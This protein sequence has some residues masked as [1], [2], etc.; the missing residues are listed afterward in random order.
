MAVGRHFAGSIAAAALLLF[1][2]LVPAL[3]QQT[4]Q[5]QV[6]DAPSAVRKPELPPQPPAPTPAQTS[7]PNAASP[8]PP[9]S[10]PSSTNP[11]DQPVVTPRNGV[12]QPSGRDELAFKISTNVNYVVLPVLVKDQNG[13]LVQGLD[14]K[15]FKVLENNTPQRIDTFSADPFPISAAVVIDTG[16]PGT[17][18][19]KVKATLPS[20]VAAFAAF[21]EVSIFT[22][23][24]TWRQ[25]H[26]FSTV[27][28]NQMDATLE[29]IRGE[30]G[31][32]GGVPFA[33]GPFNSPPMVNGQPA[34][35]GSAPPAGAQVARTPSH[36]LNDAILAAAQSLITRDRTRR[37]IIF[38]VSD[39]REKGSRTSFS[40]VVK[41]LLSHNI[42][43][44]AIGVGGAAEPGISQ[45]QKIHLP[46]F[47]AGNI[48]P[49]YA[50][51]TGGESF[52][53]LSQRNIE[54]AYARV[55]QEARNQYT[56]GYAAQNP[57][58]TGYRSIEVV[59]DR[60][61]CAK[62]KSSNCVYVYSK[63]GYFP[64]PPSRQ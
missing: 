39:G 38:V 24:N 27:T 28:G 18:L 3:A 9:G 47:G 46:G 56:L 42:S 2:A 61:D 50:A 6:P 4:G 22:F 30:S 45:A 21:D 60:P 17:V 57:L 48:L 31:E 29:K 25:E 41:V 15:D 32:E 55:T 5:Q 49:K 59:V 36:V 51:S 58:D 44:Y 7:V 26:N 14:R 23:D 16:I 13:F 34:I 53:E 54:S 63:D 43:V 11:G 19:D 64:L 33:G 40:D 35:P 52:N 62:V 20:L 8:N 37:R 1:A 10:Q 12:P